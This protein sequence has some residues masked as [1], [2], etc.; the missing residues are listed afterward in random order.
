VCHSATF[1]N[2]LPTTSVTCLIAS[3]GV[4]GTALSYV[5]NDPVS[6][7]L[8]VPVGA[9]RYSKV[10]QVRSLGYRCARLLN[11]F[12][13]KRIRVHPDLDSE[14]VRDAQII[15]DFGLANPT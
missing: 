6:N 13:P 3:T 9:R 10:L 4:Y 8:S 12:M 2:P 15:L 5:P 11:G 1:C 14:H 7:D